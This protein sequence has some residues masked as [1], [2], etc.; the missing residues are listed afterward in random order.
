MRSEVGVGV[1]P[2]RLAL[3]REVAEEHVGN[4]I[5]HHEDIVISVGNSSEREFT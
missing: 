2:V 3:L 1:P 4:L 5:L